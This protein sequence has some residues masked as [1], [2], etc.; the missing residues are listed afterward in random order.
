MNGPLV[1]DLGLGPEIW[2]YLTLLSTLVLFFK[3]SR[4]GSVR[5]LDLLL[6]FV[7]AG[8]LMKLIGTG[9]RQPWAA[10]LWLFV[11]CA[12]WL[13]RCVLDLGL[14]RRPLLEPNLNA[15]GLGCAAIGLL[16]LLIAEAVA[17]PVHEGSARNPANTGRGP[18]AG[19]GARAKPDALTEP[20][21]AVIAHAPLPDTLKVRP[22][23]V[24]LARVLAG[25]GHLGLC[26]AMLAIGTRHFQ[27]VISGLAVVV[28]YLVLPYSRIAVVDCG[29]VLPAALIVTAVLLYQHAGAAGALIGLAGGWMPASLGLVPLWL[30]F[31]RG[32][33]RFRFGLAALA[34][35]G[36]CG[37][38][39]QQS[40]LL[41]EWARALGARS[42]AEAGLWPG[43]EGP[44]AGSF[45]T[46]I[47]PAFRLP[48]LVAYAVLV[49]SLSVWPPGKNLGELIALSAA[50]LVA[51]QFWYL[52]EG[53]TMVL[54]Y[55]PLMLL[56][57]FRPNLSSKRAPTPGPAGATASDMAASL[58]ARP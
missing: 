49:L 37:L 5:N 3:F 1:P 40:P 2:V 43:V 48:M 16:G 57:V 36:A 27:R 31:Y 8:G 13:A 18:Q 10:F 15:A 19:P 20:V 52:E 21:K 45:W 14:S 6:L 22:P 42:L 39:G 55:L 34:V 28:A 12:L 56:V 32:W 26:A 4:I 29:Q 47:D 7:P 35:A 9:E 33:D 41:A 38:L 17:L 24:V 46:D 23:R 30:G 58:S 54:L 50:L 25:I 44:Q 11:A 53:G 51:S